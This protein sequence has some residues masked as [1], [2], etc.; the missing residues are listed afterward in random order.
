MTTYRIVST[1]TGSFFCDVEATSEGDAI[2]RFAQ[3]RG[4]A[5]RRDMWKHTHGFD[6]LGAYPITRAA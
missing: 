2:D 3:A 1:Q 6:Y 5:D 4:Y